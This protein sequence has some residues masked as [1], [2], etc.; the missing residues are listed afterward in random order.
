MDY[1]QK[2]TAWEY[3]ESW[4]DEYSSNTHKEIARRIFK[5]FLQK[6]NENGWYCL[7]WIILIPAALFFLC[8][9]PF[10]FILIAMSFSISYTLNLLLYK[11]FKGKLNRNYDYDKGK[12]YIEWILAIIATIISLGVTVYALTLFPST[13]D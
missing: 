1:K 2:M 8:E 10:F 6:S 3:I 9:L 13:L 7:A 4:M 5:R 11:L 12:F